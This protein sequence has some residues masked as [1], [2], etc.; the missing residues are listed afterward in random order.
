M[1]KGKPGRKRQLPLFAEFVMV[2]VRLRLGLLQKQI[3]DIINILHCPAISFKD[4]YNVD[5]FIISC[6]QTSACK[7]AI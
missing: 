2:L 1:K 4:F 5:N 7:M 6:V 3:S